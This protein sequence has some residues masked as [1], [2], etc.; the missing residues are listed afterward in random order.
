MKPKQKQQR[1]EKNLRI[2]KQVAG[3]ATGAVLGAVVAGPVGALVGGVIG[4]AV[5]KAA[6]RTPLADR[7]ASSRPASRP[8]LATRA[9]TPVAA[10]GKSKH[11]AAPKA[12]NRMKASAHR[13]RRL[14]RI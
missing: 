4:T 1:G 9:R 11:A 14:R 5:G 7:L 8:R 6:E 3:G 10:R 12:F 2:R 13:S